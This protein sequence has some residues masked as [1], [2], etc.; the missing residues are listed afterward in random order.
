MKSLFGQSVFKVNIDAG[1]TCPNRDGSKGHSGC[2]YCNNDSFRPGACKP[3]LSVSKQVQNGMDYMGRRYGAKQFI[4]YFQPYTNTYA[5][6]ERLER[7]YL[8]ALSNPAIVGIAIGTRPDAVDDEKLDMIATLKRDG[9]LV[10][11]EYGIQSVYGKS[12][13]FMNR[14]HGMA[15]FQLA[16]DSTRARGIEAGAHLIVGFPTETRAEM[17]DMAGIISGTG[18]GF[19]KVHQLQVVRDTPL[20]DIY[21]QDPFYVF[22]YDEY[23]EFI[24]DFIERLSPEIVLQRLFATAPDDILIAPL[25]GRSRHRMLRDIELKLDQ[26]VTYQGRL[27]RPAVKIQ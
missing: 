8:E 25:W 15:E 13:E 22:G 19:L 4:A 26:R 20:A 1:F 10:L 21:A 11:I 6:V 14:G 2:I 23:V 9:R 17:L 3:T 12:L 24:A 27:Y 16:V 18:V 5:P 7:L